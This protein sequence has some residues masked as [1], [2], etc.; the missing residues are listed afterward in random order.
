MKVFISHSMKN[1][2]L[3]DALR[4]I[5]ASLGIDPLIAEH[6]VNVET[7]ISSKIKAMILESDLVLVV[8]TRD[9][10]DSRFVQQEIGFATDKKPLLV[11][12]EKGC[13]GQLSGFVYGRDYVT[14]DP[15]NPQPAFQRIQQ[16]LSGQKQVTDKQD[17]IGQLFL[18]GLGILFF[19]ALTSKR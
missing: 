6:V 11:V 7:T 9:G 17:A 14:L 4:S 5:A 8:L 3:V 2:N 1:E 18:V 15:W 16:V 19:A 12:V 13:E 10:F